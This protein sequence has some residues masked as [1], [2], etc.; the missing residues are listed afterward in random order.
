MTMRDAFVATM[1]DL[2]DREPRPVVITADIG[3]SRFD[4]LR[5]RHP[6]RIVN[7]GI[8]EQAMIGVAAGFALEGHRPFVHSYAPFLV[9]RPFEQI[10]LDLVHQGLGAVLV[11]IG[12]SY[13]AAGEGRTH[14]APGDVALLSTLPGVEIHVPGHA[15][16]VT[17]LLIGAAAEEHTVYVRMS[18]AQNEVSFPADGRIRPARIGTVDAPTILAIGPTLS[19]TLE[20]VADLDVTV[21]YTA[22]PLPMDGV[23]LRLATGAELL[24]IEPYL[25]GTSL[26]MLIDAMPGSPRRVSVHGVQ[27]DELRK[28]GSWQ[29]HRAAHDLDAAGIRRRFESVWADGVRSPSRL[30]VWIG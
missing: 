19:A 5:E 26:P 15:E 9:E 12:G 2:L 21:L 20:A 18:E 25:E 22:T 4:Q 30:S 6:R 27:R 1:S 13:D 29:E 17:E 14:H 24:V 10:K 7:V 8:R 16:E 28:Y 11:S 23:G 3:S